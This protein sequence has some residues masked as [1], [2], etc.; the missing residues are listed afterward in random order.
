MQRSLGGSCTDTDGDGVCDDTDNCDL[1][2]NPG[3][4]DTDGDGIGDACDVAAQ[5][6]IKLNVGTSPGTGTA[7]VTQMMV[8]GGLWP[9]VA[10]PNAGV[11]I[12]IATQCMGPNPATTTSTRVQTV[13]GT[14]KRA[15][16]KIPPA[17]APGNYFV[18]I[19][20]NA[21]GAFGSFNCSKMKVVAPPPAP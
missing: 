9:N 11:T 12:Y 4:E 15:Y 17:T 13:L 18:W 8:T 2:D 1:I 21:A 20:G 16:F 5:L 3:Q 10:I 6:K 7:G 14:T 19:T